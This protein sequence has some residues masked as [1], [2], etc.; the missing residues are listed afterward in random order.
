METTYTA[1]FGSMSTWSGQCLR[2]TEG[3]VGVSV[4]G[5]GR[6]MLCK[7][8]V[9]GCV[10]VCLCVCGVVEGAVCV[11]VC[12]WSGRGGS[13]SAEQKSRTDIPQPC[14]HAITIEVTGNGTNTRAFVG[15][16]IGCY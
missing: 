2:S 8:W 3:R 12:V 16:I 11:Y 9:E 5:A 6:G 14:P 7:C 15:A 10:C 13:A 1:I 4:S